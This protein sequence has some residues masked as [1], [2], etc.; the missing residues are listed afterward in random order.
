MSLLPKE[1]N[2]PIPTKLLGQPDGGCLPR[3]PR[4]LVQQLQVPRDRQGAVEDVCDEL[5]WNQRPP[6]KLV[7]EEL[8]DLERVPVGTGELIDVVQERGCWP[9]R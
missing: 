5:L 2:G 6:S 8:L 7:A 4:L 1:N 9:P 3:R